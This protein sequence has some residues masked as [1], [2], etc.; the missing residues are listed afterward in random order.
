MPRKLRNVGAIMNPNMSMLSS[1]TTVDVVARLMES[2]H[3]SC[4]VV[5]EGDRPIGMVWERDLVNKVVGRGLAPGEVQC[6]DVMT[7]PVHT[8]H[9]DVDLGTAYEEMEER[10]SRRFAVADDAGRLVG[11]I[12]QSDLIAGLY[13][14][15]QEM[16]SENEILH[17]QALSR[18]RLAEQARIARSLQTQFLPKT[19]PVLGTFEIAG[20][21]TQ[22]HEVGGDFFDYIPV[23][24][25]SV[26]VVIG[27]VVGNGIPA[28]MLMVMTR[29]ILRSQAIEHSSPAEVLRKANLTFMAEDMEGQFVTIFYCVARRGR[30]DLTV[31]SAGHLPMMIRRRAS[32]DIEFVDCAGLPLGVAQEADYEEARVSLAPGDVALLYTDGLVEVRNAA[33][34][35]FRVARLAEAFRECADE[36]PADV[37]AQLSA[38]VDE[39]AADDGLLDDRTAVVLRCI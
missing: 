31:A 28:A 23:D 32:S 29:S 18:E 26:G 6:R 33:G 24:D 15:V 20:R 38:K 19:A 37:L 21:N 1:D 4:V 11:L 5:T 25:E 39:F 22:A 14:E 10:W 8:V 2:K 12:T 34:D 16:L 17:Q 36:P 27:D 9:H 3:V 13:Q 35:M 7:S 30:R